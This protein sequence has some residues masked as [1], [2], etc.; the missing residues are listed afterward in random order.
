LPIREILGNLIPVSLYT[1]G[2]IS[3]EVAEWFIAALFLKERFV[4]KLDVGGSNPP[5]SALCNQTA[6]STSSGKPLFI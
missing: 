4:G 5:L 3:G 6:Q 1:A 2:L